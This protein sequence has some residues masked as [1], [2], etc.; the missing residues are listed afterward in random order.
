MNLLTSMLTTVSENRYKC[1]TKDCKL[2]KMI[3]F[4]AMEEPE[5]PTCQECNTPYTLIPVESSTDIY[6]A[7]QNADARVGSKILNGE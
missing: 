2:N 4:Y 6:A 1:E 7:I 5:C 3:A